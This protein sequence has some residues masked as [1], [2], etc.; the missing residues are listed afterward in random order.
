MGDGVEKFP[1]KRTRAEDVAL[2]VGCAIVLGVASATV[3]LALVGTTYLA[4]TVVD[5]LRHMSV[6]SNEHD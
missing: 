1:F 4:R 3:V 6:S 5:K 2:L